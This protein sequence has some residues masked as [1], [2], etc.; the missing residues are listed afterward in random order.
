MLCKDCYWWKVSS[1]SFH[2]GIYEHWQDRRE[3]CTALPEIIRRGGNKE[4]CSIFEERW[5]TKGGL[6]SLIEK[7]TP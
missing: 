3:L 4:I 1:V 7:R 6:S 2:E 5:Q